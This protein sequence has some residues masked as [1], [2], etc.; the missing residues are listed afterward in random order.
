MDTKRIVEIEGVKIEVDMR[1]ARRVEEMRIGTKVKVLVTTSYGGPQ[2]HSGVI[3]GFE[4]FE[5][6]PTIVVAYLV[7][8]F[9]K[10]ELKF[11][12]YNAKSKEG[13]ELVAAADGV[14]DLDK[15]MVMSQFEREIATHEVA[16]EAVKERRAY[17]ER[18]F[19]QYWEVVAK[20]E[21]VDA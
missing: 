11:L 2:V 1:T 21:S 15:E 6:L 14:L 18:H 13:H 20:P 3:V 4:P 12:H 10:T 19:Q 9:S 17:F 7:T 8:D 16:I 5:K